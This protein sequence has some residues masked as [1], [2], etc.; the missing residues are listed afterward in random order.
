MNWVTPSLESVRD[1]SGVEAYCLLLTEDDRPL[2]GAAGFL[3]FCMQGKLSALLKRREFLGAVRERMLTTTNGAVPVFKL[4]LSGLGVSSQVSADALE[5]ALTDALKM[6]E[7]AQVSSV[8][9]SVSPLSPAT[10]RMRERLLESAFAAK[11]DGRC[12]L[13]EKEA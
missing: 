7:L 6:L 4:F 11:F 10:E 8:A 12:V 2:D 13:F 5:T 9:L 1:L 3:D